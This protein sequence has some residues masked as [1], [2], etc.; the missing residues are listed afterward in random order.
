MGVALGRKLPGDP[1]AFRVVDDRLYLNVN[2]DIQ[3][4]W[5]KDVSGNIAKA[6]ENWP[7]I[8]DVH[9]DQL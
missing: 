2:K 7:E 6:N 8:V 5:L 9:P 1:E 3:N 4:T